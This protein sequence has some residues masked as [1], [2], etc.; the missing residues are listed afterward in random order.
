MLGRAHMYEIT[1][2]FV[3]F[4]AKY[5]PH[6]HAYGYGTCNVHTDRDLCRVVSHFSRA[7]HI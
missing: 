1:S 7:S 6:P 2:N 3:T 4:S 5:I